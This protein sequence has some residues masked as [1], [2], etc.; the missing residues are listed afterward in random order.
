MELRKSKGEAVD[1]NFFASRVAGLEAEASRQE[2]DVLATYG[3]LMQ[4][5]EG[6]DP[7]IAPLRRALAVWGLTADDIGVLSIHGTS[8]QA[9]EKNESYMWNTILKTLDRTAGNAVPIMAQK[10]LVGHAKGGAAAWQM[11]GLLQS[12]A[13]GTVPG[14]R[15]ADNVDALFQEHSLLMFPSKTIQTDGITAGVM[16]C[17]SSYRLAYATNIFFSRHSVLAKLAERLLLSA[18]VTFLPQRRPLCSSHTRS[19]TRNAI[20]SRINQCQK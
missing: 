3:M 17:P 12:I 5:S 6:A 8:T 14:N 10:S 1:D 11:A 16:V 7:H 13:S 9:N 2:K 19:D 4:N 15:N 20:S 18:H